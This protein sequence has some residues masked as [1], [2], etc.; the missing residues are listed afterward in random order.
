M[1]VNQLLSSV[2]QSH[3]RS[4]NK[5]ETAAAEVCVIIIKLT[6]MKHDVRLMKNYVKLVCVFVCIRM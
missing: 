4:G 2:H 6:K 3:I 5:Y 1:S